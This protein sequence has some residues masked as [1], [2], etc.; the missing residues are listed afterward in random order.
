[1]QQ[2]DMTLAEE[3]ATLRAEVADQ[4]REIAALRQSEQRYREI[5]ENANDLIHSLD[6]EGRIL[7]TNRLWRD[8]L[9]YTAAEAT[10]MRIFDIVDLDCR[11]KCQGIFACLM[12]G[13]KTPP[14]EAVFVSKDGRK[15]QVEGRCNP[16][17]DNG[18]AV[19]L[20]GIF[21]DI[22]ERKNLEAQREALI[23]QLKEAVANIRTLEGYLPICASC[24]KVRDDKGYWNGIEEYIRTHT[25]ADFTHGMCPDCAKALYPQF[26]TK[27]GGRP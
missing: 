14:T 19:E 10:R 16:K 24:K 3:V 2:H 27:H 5:F 6:A 25:R 13:E 9:G 4:Q 8:T 11:D 15:I 1:M 20:M 7:Y 12:R 18:K 22:T 21:R 17:Y 23:E 26:M